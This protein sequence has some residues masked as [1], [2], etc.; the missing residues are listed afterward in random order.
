LFDHINDGVNQIQFTLDHLAWD[1]VK[2]ELTTPDSGRINDNVAGIIA[3]EGSC[4]GQ[5]LVFILI[6]VKDGGQLVF[7]RIGKQLMPGFSYLS[8]GLFVCEIWRTKDFES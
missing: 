7:L 1:T 8:A 4:I 6:A 5:R 3:G 2:L